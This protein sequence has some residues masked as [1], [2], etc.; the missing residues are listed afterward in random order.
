M[1]FDII[2]YFNPEIDVDTVTATV[3]VLL[4]DYE[5]LYRARARR[6]D[7][8]LFRKELIKLLELTILLRNKQ[9]LIKYLSYAR[10]SSE[11]IPLII[12]FIS[13]RK[14]FSLE[15]LEYIL[16]LLQTSLYVI[17]ALA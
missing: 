7:K 8:I 11:V 14:L 16:K 13:I 10:I 2:V 6:I 15:N 1:Y 12:R 3:R 17:E 9:M 5:N 4:V